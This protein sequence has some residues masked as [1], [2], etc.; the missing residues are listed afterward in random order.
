MPD[1]LSVLPPGPQVIPF[2]TLVQALQADHW[3][4]AT[5]AKWVTRKDHPESLARLADAPALMPIIRFA[6]RIVG[7]ERETITGCRDASVEVTIE[8][9][10]AAGGWEDSANLWAHI[11]SIVT[12]TSFLNTM[13]AAGC[14]D[15]EVM[16]PA[17]SVNEGGLFDVS[18]ARIKLLISTT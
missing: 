18:M 8:I 6:P 10:V 3:L 2:R 1:S 13:V 4:A 14:W 16:E 7:Y 5:V 11:E 9:G 15:V 17:T 12:S